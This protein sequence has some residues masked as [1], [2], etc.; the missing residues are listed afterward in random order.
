MLVASAFLAVATH[1]ATHAATAPAD[2]ASHA[3]DGASEHHV[4]VPAAQARALRAVE[5]RWEPAL[6]LALAAVAAAF[7]L[8]RRREPVVPSRRVLWDAGDDWR[9]LLV[10]APPAA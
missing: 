10:G 9:S 1:V 5:S 8:I 2:V 6:G 7:T 3:T 4:A